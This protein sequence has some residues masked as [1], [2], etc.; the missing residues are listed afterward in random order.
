MGSGN[1]DELCAL[2]VRF[3]HGDRQYLRV[4][5]IVRM[6]SGNICE[7]RGDFFVFELK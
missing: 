4:A 7:V 3:A 1:L 5:C 2:E 6:G